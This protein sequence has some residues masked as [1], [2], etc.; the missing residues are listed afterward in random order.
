MTFVNRNLPDK[1]HIEGIQRIDIRDK[2]FREMAANLLIHREYSHSFPAKFLIF[3]DKVITENWNKPSGQNHVTIDNLET[4]PKNPMIARVFKEL[5]W[6]EELGS[7]RKNIK[8]YAPLYFHDYQ[9]IIENEE[10]FVFS[11]T[12]RD[13]NENI[14][15]PEYTNNQLDKIYTLINENINGPVNE[16][17]GPV[18][19]PVNGLDGPVN[20]NVK[21]EL[22]NIILLLLNEESANRNMLID[23]LEKGRTTITRYLKLLKDA[24]IIEY[25]GSDKTGGY[26]LTQ[27]AKEKLQ[28]T[29]TQ[30]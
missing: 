16:M 9:I 1:F 25:I 22:F 30:P 27:K 8:K 26:H 11:I 17:V 20:E 6:V 2:I 21:K 12:Y 13:C 24:N 28:L 23:K 4:H 14:N 15:S 19:G 7:G 29:A 3:S 10:K 18:N 5:G